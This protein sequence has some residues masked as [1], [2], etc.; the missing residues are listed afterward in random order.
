MLRRRWPHLPRQA[1]RRS[2]RARFVV[3]AYCPPLRIAEV[4]GRVRLGLDGLSNVEG[5]SL[6]EAGDALVAQLLQ[7][8]TAVRTAGIGPLT[9]ECGADPQLLD[10]V[11]TLAYSVEG[12]DDVRELVFG[13]SSVDT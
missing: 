4:D 8:A 11:W 5:A 13:P 9:S 7:V 12:G 3:D 2:T 10:F 6:Q 1:A